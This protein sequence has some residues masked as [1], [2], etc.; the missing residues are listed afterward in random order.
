MKLGRWITSAVALTLVACAGASVSRVRE[1]L[2]AM[3]GPG[4]R[5]GTVVPLRA[6]PNAKVI[7]SS[8]AGLPAASFLASQ[9]NRGEAL[10]KER[11][12]SCH[13]PG[14]L[15]GQR[16]VDSWNDRR[17]YDLYTLVRATMP[18]SNPGSMK[19]PEYLDLTAYLLKANHHAPLKS[20][21]LVADTTSMRKTRI[22]VSTP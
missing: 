5:T 11:C 10:Y 22:A 18:L 9:A 8:A 19:D 20:D 7:L 12:S 14:E 2:G 6:D 3:L 4:A 16:F 15:I 13:A 21:S 17:V 1:P